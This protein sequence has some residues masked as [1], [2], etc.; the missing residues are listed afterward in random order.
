[1]KVRDVMR[2]EFA[3]TSPD[4]T[5]LEAGRL[6]MTTAEE[7]LPVVQGGELVGII[8][9]RDILNAIFTRL[10]EDFYLLGSQGVD[11]EDVGALQSLLKQSVAAMMKTKVVVATPDLP[12]FRAGATMLS[13]RIRRLPV[14]ADGV[15]LG[16]VFA[17]DIHAAII[18]SVSDIAGTEI[19]ESR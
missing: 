9:E 15:L 5:V 12:A 2:V 8:A 3:A 11:F 17:R 6:M 1:M 10:S 14:V 7:A 4:A 18:R 19:G 16:V 13:K